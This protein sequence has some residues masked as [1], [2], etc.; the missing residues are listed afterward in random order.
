MIVSW[1][2]KVK[3]LSVLMKVVRVAFIESE[4]NRDW[5]NNGDRGEEKG[6][7][8]DTKS[9]RVPVF[10]IYNLIITKQRTLHCQ[11]LY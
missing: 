7:E 1:S 2:E 5:C 4:E 11:K 10:L 6:K 3:E 8:R 9:E